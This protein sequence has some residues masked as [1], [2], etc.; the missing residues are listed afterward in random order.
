MNIFDRYVLKNI[1]VASV[2]VSLTLTI[3]IFLTQS[4]RFLELVIESGAS[5][6]SFWVLTFLALPRFL[7]VVVP[8]SLMVAVVF[9][10]N[11]MT[12]DS[13]LVVARSAGFSPV[14]LARPAL[15]L[16]VGITVLLWGVTLWGA[17]KSLSSMYYMRQQIQAQFSNI[18]L[19]EGVFNQVAKGLT[20]Y[21]RDRHSDGEMQGLMIYD[22]RIKNALPSMV[23]AKRGV[24]VS[25]NGS[26]QV[27]VYEG[28]RQEYDPQRRVLRRLNFNRY[29]I[30]LPEGGAVHQRWA[31]PGERTIGEL[32]HPDMDNQRDVE[33]LHIFR[34]EIHRRLVAPLL[35]VVYTLISCT[36]LLLGPVDRRGQGKRIVLIVLGVVVVQGLFLVTFNLAKH[37][38]L[39]LI[40]MYGF[41]F[42]PM[43]L[44]GF[45][46][47]GSGDG[48]RRKL[49]YRQRKIIS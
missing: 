28:S 19:R 49:M 47:S 5:A 33:N 20:V 23:L 24:I 29:T 31:E 15:V 10:Y 2:F 11:R 43:A 37:Y 25:D 1:F 21:V 22:N 36:F 46:L 16:A 13:E 48:L 42:V 6:S 9:T 34:L 40:L 26:Y 30:D 3:V 14:A 27:L 32:L 4:L 35:A 18:L 44:C 17:P 39:G 45:M 38:I 41:V 7:E 12:T 8:L